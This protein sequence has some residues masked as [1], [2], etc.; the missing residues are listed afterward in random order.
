[1]QLTVM[2]TDLQQFVGSTVPTLCKVFLQI[3]LQ[4]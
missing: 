2:S 1:M 4:M 3:F